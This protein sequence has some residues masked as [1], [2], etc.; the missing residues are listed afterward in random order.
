[1]RK[2]LFVLLLFITVCAQAESTVFITGS[3]RGIGLGLVKE[4]AAH[5]W[6]VIATCR[7]PGSAQELQ[8]F[9]Q[10]NNRIIIE[11]LDVTDSTEIAALSDKYR[12]QP[13]DVLINNAGLLPVDEWNKPLKELDFDYARKVFDVNTFAPVRIMQAFMDHVAA[14]G[15]KKI[16]N[17]SSQAGSFANASHEPRRYVYRGSKAALNMFTFD[18]AYELGQLGITTIALHP[19]VVHSQTDESF[20]EAKQRFAGLITVEESAAKIYRTVA[21]LTPADNGKFFSYEPGRELSW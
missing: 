8:T 13:I 6:R 3:N 9:A 1:M 20:E 11:Q 18:I 19:G 12:D 21:G 14:S 7:T 16:V 2:L 5:G 17:I 10:A 4:Y 15:E